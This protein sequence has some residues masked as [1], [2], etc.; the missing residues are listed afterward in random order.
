LLEKLIKQYDLKTLIL[1]L[2]SQ[3]EGYSIE[4][5]DNARIKTSLINYEVSF[6][7]E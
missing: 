6:L 2:H 3:A 1:N 5:N 7:I 4:I